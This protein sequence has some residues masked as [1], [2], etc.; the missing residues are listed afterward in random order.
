MFKKL[1]TDEYFDIIKKNHKRYLDATMVTHL[2]A[3]DGAESKALIIERYLTHIQAYHQVEADDLDYAMTGPTVA[4]KVGRGAFASLLGMGVG[5]FVFG[6]E[7]KAPAGDIFGAKTAIQGGFAAT[8]GVSCS[9]LIYKAWE[10]SVEKPTVKELEAFEKDMEEAGFSKKKY[11]DMA[12]SLVKLFHFRECLLLGLEN[13]GKVNMRT[14]FKNRFPPPFVDA[15]FN[16]A[17]EVYF[18]QQ[19]NDLFHEA[20]QGIYNIH[21]KEITDEAAQPKFIKWF[22]RHFESEKIRQRFTQQMQLDFIN[23]CLRF[24]E[25]EKDAKGFMGRHP[26]F[27]ASMMGLIAG[28]VALA[29]VA[30]MSAVI[31]LAGLV[32]LGVVVASIT[33]VSHYFAV[34]KIDAL[35]YVR[36][37]GNRQ[38]IGKAID[39]IG[40]ERNRLRHLI[41]QVVPTTRKDL[42]DLKRYDDVNESSFLKILTL[43]KTQNVALG[44]VRAWVRELASRFQESKFIQI[45]LSDR[46]K[47]II[48]D[49]HDQTEYLQKVL[50]GLM[51]KPNKA[52]LGYLTQFIND[53]KQYLQHPDNAGFITTFESVQKIK[54]QIMEVVGHLPLTISLKLPTV[55]I[56][57]YTAPVNQGGLGGLLSDFD[58]VRSLASVVADHVAADEHHPYYHLIKTAFSI[59]LKLNAAANQAF[60]F[61]GDNQYRQLLGSP[62]DDVAHRE[63][64][65]TSQTIQRYLTASFDFLCSLNQYNNTITSWTQAFQNNDEFILYRMLLVKQL[66]NLADPN[67]HRVD[68]FIKEEIKLFARQQLKCN[69]DIAFDDILNQALL[70]KPDPDAG[71]LRDTFGYSRSLNDLAYVADAVRVDIAYVS[72][73]VSPKDLICFEAE[74][75]I[76]RSGSK[77]IFGYNSLEH[78]I[79]QHS[80]Q[81]SA[82]LDATMTTTLNFIDAIKGHD[83]LQQTGTMKIYLQV[84]LHEAQELKEKIN[85]LAEFE[86]KLP[87]LNTQLRQDAVVA[88]DAFITKISVMEEPLLPSLPSS[89]V[90]STPLREAVSVTNL[91]VSSSLTVPIPS[92]E[93]M[94]TGPDTN[95][96]N[97]LPQPASR[98]Q[99]PVNS[100]M[101]AEGVVPDDVHGSLKIL[102][103]STSS[104]DF[105]SRKEKSTSILSEFRA[106]L[107]HYIDKERLEEQKESQGQSVTHGFFRHHAHTRQDKIVAATT[108]KEALLQHEGNKRVAWENKAIYQT[109]PHLKEIINHHLTKLGFTDLTS[110]FQSRMAL[111]ATV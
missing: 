84:V 95:H 93:I 31:P 110:L 21:D 87:A 92:L 111:A 62:Q 45:D 106:K 52:D 97:S 103:H 42:A 18:L 70:I 86:T 29:L 5:A 108:L 10:T 83:L 65:I 4:E 34:S 3:V 48:H 91:V 100:F 26:Y 76:R 72:T 32:G 105:E 101:H 58:Q 22:K 38:A 94:A 64:S 36:D 53:T 109:N 66:A 51:T 82:L 35:R 25:Q 69:P 37:M 33:A 107:D 75:H 17:I 104:S 13:K 27:V 56:N 54:E 88:L 49:A 1:S 57:F 85:K 63:D 61:R 40:N 41:Q 59:N 68:P 39:S 50:L 9:A 24:L 20:F 60:I 102:K 46:I 47:S 2:A 30:A 44:G 11:A 28:S 55:L 8:I 89:P 96:A 77:L 79:P 98:S 7:Q 14:A 73:S 12:E 19:L 6:T 90:L 43:K 81:F 23:Q 80:S 67:N 78:L 15:D 74:H 99:T 16:I 71:F